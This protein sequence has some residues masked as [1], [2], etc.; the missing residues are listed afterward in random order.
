MQVALASC[1]AVIDGTFEADFSPIAVP[2]RISL[3]PSVM[4]L[5]AMQ[6]LDEETRSLRE[7]EADEAH[8]SSYS[9]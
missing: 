1:A 3:V 6:K 8:G 5:E 9:M 2:E 4:L 7:G